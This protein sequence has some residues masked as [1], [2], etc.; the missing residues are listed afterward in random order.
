MSARMSNRKRKVPHY[1]IDIGL[2]WQECLDGHKKQFDELIM[3]S[4]DCEVTSVR[5]AMDE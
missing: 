2:V 1:S 4:L 3:V 5:V